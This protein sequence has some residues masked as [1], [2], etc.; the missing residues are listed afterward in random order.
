VKRVLLPLS[1]ALALAVGAPAG[2]QPKP[3]GSAAPAAGS[4]APAAGSASALPPGHPAVGEGLPAGHPAVDD[5]DD[6]DQPQPKG[7]AHGVDPRFFN[8]PE[9]TAVDDPTLPA[10]V[11]V[12]T[13][14]DAQD[15]PLPR[16]PITLGVLHS[17]VAKGESRERVA[18]EA[19]AEG[20]AR[21]EGLQVGSG[22]T[23]RVSTT[24]GPATYAHAPFPLSDRVGKRVVVH[25][26]ET[27][28]NLEELP[29]AMQALVY[30]SLREDSI[31]VE[32]LLSVFN[33]GPVAW[34]PDLV[35]DLPRGFKAF[36]KQ[37]AMGD[38]RVEEVEGTG[39]ALRGTFPP[40][41]QDL[42]FR[43]QIPLSDEAR[44]SF[45]V[46]MPAHTMLAR[47]MAEAS[48]TMGLEV[49]GFPQAQRTESREG[50]RLL[51][52]ERQAARAQGGVSTLGVTLTGLPTTGPGRWI[53]V[54]LAIV[55]LGAGLVYVLQRGEGGSFDEDARRDLD[56]AREA[57]LG[58]IVALE[59]AHKQG[60]IGPKTY[61]R[62]RAS[63]LDALARIVR[64][65]EEARPKPSP[66]KGDR[67]GRTAAAR[68]KP[69]PK[70]RAPEP[71]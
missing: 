51:V 47:V 8:P 70:R 69:R 54:A 35:V 14:K 37:D 5:E 66:S 55:A 53:A 48:R 26:Y 43:Y 56:D 32:Q 4:A 16:A 41:R 33:L 61:A 42:D 17:T 27:A 25:S 28:A 34:T 10:G 60:E 52:T 68:D 20:S 1:L 45:D 64:M 36:N 11:I 18:R 22:T 46:G 71:T 7:G 67:G 57:L 21:F 49:S 15:K 29:V 30:V 39:V 2:A 19:D 24:R 40:G 65:I 58:E 12:A 3:H 13:I 50:K 63:L 59:R 31:Q 44:Q 62:V 9:D 38:A 6:G 23:Y